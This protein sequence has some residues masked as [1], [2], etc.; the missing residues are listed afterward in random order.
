[1]QVL[2]GEQNLFRDYVYGVHITLGILNAP[3]MYSIR[4]VSDGKYKLIKNLNVEGEF[5]N[6]TKH[7]GTDIRQSEKFFD[8]EQIDVW[9]A[10]GKENSNIAHSAEFYY[11][12][13]QIELYDLQKDLFEF[14]N[15]VGHPQYNPIIKQLDKQLNVWITQQADRGLQTEFEALPRRGN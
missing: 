4:Y 3:E 2:L 6:L 10:S 15:L 7:I 5:S 11:K 13:P 1:M 14:I 12:R 9:F 8:P